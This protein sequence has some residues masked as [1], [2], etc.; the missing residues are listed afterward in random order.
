M[1]SS[2]HA[3][4]LLASALEEWVPHEGGGVGTRAAKELRR[5]HQFELALQQ[6]LDLTEWVGYDVQPH[7]LGRHRAEVIK[8][9]VDRL[10][11][12]NAE[13]LAA[14]K[15]AEDS[16]GDL[17]SLEIVRAAIAKAEGGAA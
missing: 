17:K 1:S 11:A 4:L 8:Q 9:R 5:L 10:Q 15:V 14:L 16:V 7:E 6:W 12:I 3:T 13:F 2:K